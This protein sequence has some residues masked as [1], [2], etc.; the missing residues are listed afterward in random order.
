[1]PPTRRRACR[2]AVRGARRASRNVRAGHASQSRWG[3]RAV[4]CHDRG[5]PAAP[6]KEFGRMTA[7]T[8]DELEKIG[9]ADEVQLASRRADGTLRE[10]VTI[11][12]VR[13][14]EDLYVRA[15]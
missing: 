13:R 15:F 8:N 3:R 7:W 14:S 10:P 5:Q 12:V 11:W 1:L 9:A 4:A 6:W 2:R